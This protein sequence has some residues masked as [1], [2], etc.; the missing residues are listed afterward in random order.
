ME[1]KGTKKEWL[2]SESSIGF[3]YALN[4]KKEKNAFSFHINNDGEIS[5]K[6]IEANALLISKAPE[7]LGM[8]QKVLIH[9]DWSYENWTSNHGE[10]IENE[11][12]ELIKEATEL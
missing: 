2:K 11:I 4:E 7:M 1:F 9:V 12:K 8:L 5:E 3:V 6:E 10:I